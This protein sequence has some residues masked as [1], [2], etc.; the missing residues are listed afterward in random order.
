MSAS[1]TPNHV[2]LGERPDEGSSAPRYSW[3]PQTGRALP[4][5]A[6]GLYVGE[7]NQ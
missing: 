6:V 7:V 5:A 4:T 1:L 2:L 3:Q